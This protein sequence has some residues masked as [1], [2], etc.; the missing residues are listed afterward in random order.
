MAARSAVAPRPATA[1]TSC[2]ARASSTAT[3]VPTA[4][5]RSR[6][7]FTTPTPW[8]RGD[9]RRPQ[10]RAGGTRRAR[11]QREGRDRPLGRT[12]SSP[13]CSR[14]RSAVGGDGRLDGGRVGPVDELGHP[15]TDPGAIVMR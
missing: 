6:A 10:Q 15:Q 11:R 2:P 3:A 13:S 12:D 9:E 8:H 1:A 4:R 7:I 5:R 14:I